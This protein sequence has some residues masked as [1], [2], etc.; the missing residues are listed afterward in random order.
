MTIPIYKEGQLYKITHNP[1]RSHLLS[2]R[3]GQKVNRI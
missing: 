2:D 1:T 3:V